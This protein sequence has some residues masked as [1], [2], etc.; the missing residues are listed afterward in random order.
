[1]RATS[2]GCPLFF[3]LFPNNLKDFKVV[4]DFKDL[5]LLQSL[6][7]PHLAQLPY[8]KYRGESD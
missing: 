1:M 2:K 5:T 8:E 4:K 3:A 6:L 7:A